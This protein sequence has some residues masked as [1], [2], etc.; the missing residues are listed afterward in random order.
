MD[1]VLWY[2]YSP[3]LFQP[4]SIHR[5]YIMNENGSVLKKVRPKTGGPDLVQ[6]PQFADP[7]SGSQTHRILGLEGTF[8]SSK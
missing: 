4:Q 1:Y 7:Y 3:V 5:Q 6:G 8:K 2:S